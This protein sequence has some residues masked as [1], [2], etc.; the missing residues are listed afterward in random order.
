MLAEKIKLMKEQLD[1]ATENLALCQ[2][3]KDQFEQKAP[4]N[5]SLELTLEP[6]K[7]AIIAQ[8]KRIAELFIESDKVVLV[9]PFDG[10]VNQ[11]YCHSGQAVLQGEPIVT[12]A[13]QTPDHVVA[14]VDQN[15]P[16][17]ELL[18]REIN[19]IKRDMP[20]KVMVSR[21]SEFGPAIEMIPAR[22]WRNPDIEEWGRPVIIPVHPDMGLLINEIVGIKDI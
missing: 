11:I 8:Q 20:P 4:L 21:I 10:I 3:R 2:L 5:T 1:E 18:N 7:K 16:V 17:D 14:W 9:A 19:L 13:K 15:T 22:L 6:L 12:V